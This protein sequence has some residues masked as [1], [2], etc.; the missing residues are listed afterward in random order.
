MN[1]SNQ[2]PLSSVTVLSPLF[3]SSYLAIEETADLQTLT[4]FCSAFILY[5]VDSVS[6]TLNDNRKEQ[7]GKL[8]SIDNFFAIA[9]RV[10]EH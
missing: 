10:N 8:M 1:I 9:E 6:K 4:V 7:I 2:H 3:V 5:L